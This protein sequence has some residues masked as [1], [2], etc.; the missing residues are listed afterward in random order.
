LENW[1]PI[2]AAVEGPTGSWRMLDGLGKQYGTIE[3]RRVMNDTDT[4]YRVTFRGEVIG[5]ATTLRLACEQVH[6]AF[7]R[8]HGPGGGPIAG[9]GE[10]PAQ[11]HRGAGERVGRRS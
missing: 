11:E 4:R 1:H 7:L 10:A 8:A 6:A 9:W 5:W 2:L 3:I